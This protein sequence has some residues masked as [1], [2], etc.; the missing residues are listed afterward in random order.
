MESSWSNTNG[1]AS[2]G[3]NNNVV[4][5]NINGQLREAK[6]VNVNQRRKCHY[7]ST[8]S[9]CLFIKLKI[10]KYRTRLAYCPFTVIKTCTLGASPSFARAQILGRLGGRP[11]GFDVEF[12]IYLI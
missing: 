5:D 4:G 6:D 9:N 7:I 12:D 1:T 3:C 10:K 11:D 8:K 2:S